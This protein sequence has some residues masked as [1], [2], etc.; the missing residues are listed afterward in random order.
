MRI[1]TEARG[2][3]AREEQDYYRKMN[4]GSFARLADRS[5]CETGLDAQ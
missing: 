4:F 3:R 1:A 5:R 2:V